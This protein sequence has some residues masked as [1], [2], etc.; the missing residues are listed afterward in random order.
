MSPGGARSLTS[1]MTKSE[2][3]M[4]M[5]EDHQYDH[6]TQPF[7]IECS[8]ELSPDEVL[9]MNSYG[10]DRDES[11]CFSCFCK[12]DDDYELCDH[13]GE[14][15][16]NGYVTLV[17]DQKY[18]F[19]C[20]HE[21]SYSGAKR[22]CIDCTGTL[23]DDEGVSFD[24][25]HHYICKG[26]YWARCTASGMTPKGLA[27]ASCKAPTSHADGFTLKGDDVLCTSCFEERMKNDVV[28]NF[29]RLC[30]SSPEMHLI[31]AKSIR[32]ALKMIVG[33]QLGVA[34]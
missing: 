13:C 5:N 18:H 6:M 34:Q 20:L 3:G 23:R 25:G 1:E 16:G 26:C 22:T 29:D 15:I 2:R 33:S 14:P 4:E 28:E 7:C 11:S 19:D 21:I 32:A 12:S 31:E 9:W 27:C 10:I 24:G 30:V 8:T 17:D